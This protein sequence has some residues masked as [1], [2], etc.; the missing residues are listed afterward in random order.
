MILIPSS[1]GTLY[2]RGPSVVPSSR[3][4][5]WQVRDKIFTGGSPSL[6]LT[7]C[8]F[9]RVAS[10]TVRAKRATGSQG[11]LTTVGS[12]FVPRQLPLPQV[13][14]TSPKRKY[15]ILPSPS[16]IDPI[17]QKS[18]SSFWLYLTAAI[19]YILWQSSDNVLA[20]ENIQQTVHYA[21]GDVRQTTNTV[22][23]KVIQDPNTNEAFIFL[24]V[25]PKPID[26]YVDRPALESAIE[27]TL[28][29]KKVCYLRGHGG[30]GKTQLSLKHALKNL[31]DYSH[32]IFISCENTDSLKASLADV[33]KY[34]EGDSGDE[35][36]LGK[37][38]AFLD[39]DNPYWAEKK[40]PLVIID[41]VDDEDVA[42]QIQPFLEKSFVGDMIITGRYDILGQS[43][44]KQTNR[45]CEIPIN[46]LTLTEALEVFKAALNPKFIAHYF[47]ESNL[48]KTTQLL[49]NTLG[50]V[51][52]CI[53]LGATYINEASLS[54]VDTA[55]KE[56]NSA[57]T[58]VLVAEFL[59]AYED[60]AKDVGYQRSIH[61]ATESNL[62]RVIDNIPPGSRQVVQDFVDFLSCMAPQQDFSLEIDD[63]LLNTLREFT[64]KPA[65]YQQTNHQLIVVLRTALKALDKRFLIK[66]RSK[67]SDTYE[68]SFPLPVKQA[69]NLR[70]RQAFEE[71]RKK[72]ELDIDRDRKKYIYQV[73]NKVW[74]YTFESRKE[75]YYYELD[76]KRY[77]WYQAVVTYLARTENPDLYSFSYI[78]D[79]L[80]KFKS[81]GFIAELFVQLTQPI[82]AI[83]KV[84]TRQAAFYDKLD[85]NVFFVLKNI[86]DT[87]LENIKGS[88][89]DVYAAYFVI[90]DMCLEKNIEISKEIMSKVRGINTQS[91]YHFHLGRLQYA[92]S[93][94]PEF[95]DEKRKQKISEAISS[96]KTNETKLEEKYNLEQ[97]YYLLSSFYLDLLSLSEKE[98]ETLT[99]FEE[100]KK[101]LS[102]AIQEA[103]FNA[104]YEESYA[105]YLSSAYIELPSFYSAN[106]LSDVV[107]HRSLAQILSSKEFKELDDEHKSMMVRY[108]RHKESRYEYRDYLSGI[109]RN[110]PLKCDNG[111]FFAQHV[112]KNY[113]I[114]QMTI[115]SNKMDDS[116]VQVLMKNLENCSHLRSLSLNIDK[117][118]GLGVSA[119]AESIK[120][121]RTID[122]LSLKLNSNVDE[123]TIAD[124]IN[125]AQPGFKLILINSS[126]LKTLSQL[127]SLA[128]SR[129][130]IFTAK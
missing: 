98:E 2:S 88:K 41:N 52:L 114:H 76:K 16:K 103:P 77:R 92:E 78:I 73:L 26:K 70:L 126:S 21:G 29:S 63:N 83:A 117:I 129:S 50:G 104:V 42:Q 38:K 115:V 128:A 130:V 44:L 80:K 91:G 22:F 84:R 6:P 101:Y 58:S 35:S 54:D 60:V 20:T 67:G 113:F 4:P 81:Q 100:G 61:R 15:Q 125:A 124:L 95:T 12:V 123:A 1:V 121:N 34:L 107:Y 86:L 57:D 94:T 96:L 14:F 13:Y 25:V 62:R 106:S 31:N 97:T 66:T 111:M 122:D 82:Q 10:P 37:V 40:P 102:L 112:D 23:I 39:P 110:S 27:T 45:I 116:V 3:N 85:K 17:A 109:L 48:P 9:Q 24:N 69:I 118:T 89:K 28:R 8:H 108:F 127:K 30:N 18:F 64:S 36:Q 53:Q 19:A 47:A 43:S 74:I 65:D 51:P 99:L 56:L 7:R 49:K 87:A 79:R 33:V 32:V 119:I 93:R 46:Q 55:E 90:S 71:D 68:L 72:T 5:G 59:N 120:V 11:L 105:D 75:S